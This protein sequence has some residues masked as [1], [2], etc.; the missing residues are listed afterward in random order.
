MKFD[1]FI[2]TLFMFVFVMWVSFLF[3]VAI[4]TLNEMK[5]QAIEHGAAHYDAT[6]AEFVWNNPPNIDKSKTN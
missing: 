6:T 1:T 4:S 2:P 5:K 3:V